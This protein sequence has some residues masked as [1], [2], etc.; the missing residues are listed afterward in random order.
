MTFL[1]LTLRGILGPVE[2]G[3]TLTLER[4]ERAW[5]PAAAPCYAYHGKLFP[6]EPPPPDAP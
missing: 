5:T 4:F 2:H 1:Q 3:N 6:A